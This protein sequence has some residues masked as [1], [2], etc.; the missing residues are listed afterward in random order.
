LH[1]F[2]WQAATG[3]ISVV[4]AQSE[5]ESPRSHC[6]ELDHNFHFLVTLQLRIYAIYSLDKRVLYGVFGT[7]V[8]AMVSAIAIHIAAFW[9]ATGK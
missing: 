2:R 6:H 8:I 5:V 4:V 7:F 9:N 3:I 1:F